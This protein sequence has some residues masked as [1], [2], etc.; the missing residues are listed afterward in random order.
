MD[1][2]LASSR[3][4]KLS[5][6]MSEQTPEHISSMDWRINNLT[7]TTAPFISP[8]SSI[9]V[10]AGAAVTEAAII[11]HGEE[12]IG[13]TTP[14]AT[15]LFLNL[16]QA[17]HLQAEQL[18]SKCI[19]NK[20]EFGH[21]LEEIDVFA[22]YEQMMASIV[23]AHTSLESFVNEEIPDDYIHKVTDSRCTQHYNKEQIERYLNLDTKLGDI[24]PDVLQVKSLK[25]G[26]LWSDFNKL[27]DIRDRVIH[28]K[29]K[30]REFQGEDKNS[31]WNVILCKPLPKT[32]ETAKSLIEYFL[33][34]KNKK[35][36]W[37]EKCPF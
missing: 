9:P 24:L 33:S 35:P 12:R 20:N 19:S 18:I 34:T 21:L 23:F 15:A 11:H 25:G 32:Y 8:G 6:F 4:V 1:A 10:P 27:K 26:K 28:M 3:Q 30:D 5:E 13:I 31:I 2:L 22:F 14:N 36:R 17:C 37:F 7:W 16:S 29:T